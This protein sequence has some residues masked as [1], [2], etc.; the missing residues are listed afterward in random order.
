[1]RA[2]TDLHKRG[3]K[4]TADFADV[5]M[6]FVAKGTV[7][8]HGSVADFGGSHNSPDSG[9]TST[10]SLDTTTPGLQRS[11]LALFGSGSFNASGWA[12]L[13]TTPLAVRD[14]SVSW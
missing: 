3:S 11:T 2:F 6:S 8:F 1:M 9:L 14:C 13:C 10:F 7:L 12:R 5:P 4:R